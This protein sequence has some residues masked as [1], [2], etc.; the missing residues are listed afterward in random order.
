[1]KTSITRPESSLLSFRPTHC[2]KQMLYADQSAIDN[3]LG[4]PREASIDQIE[5]RGEAAQH[6]LEWV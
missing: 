5:E 1:M 4:L 6:R 2:A 3:H